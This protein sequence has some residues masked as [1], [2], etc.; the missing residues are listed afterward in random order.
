MSKDESEI[1]RVSVRVPPFY[2]DKPALWFMQLE[3]QFVLSNITSDSTKFHY[4]IAQLDSVYASIVEDIITGPT[5]PNKYEQLKT[6]LIKRLSVSREKKINQLLTNEELGDRKPTQFLRHLK[7][8]A[9]KDVPEEFMR[10]IWT[11]RL[12]TS[13]QSI[14]AG[15]A[16]LPLDE[17]AEL[18]DRIHEVVPIHPQVAATSSSSMSHSLTQ[19]IAALTQQ[20]QVLASKVDRMSRQRGRSKTPNGQ[21]G[22][23]RSSSERRSSANFKKFPTCWYHHKFGDKANRCVQ[24]CNFAGNGRGNL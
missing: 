19:E 9:G 24:P 3:S 15:Q 21:R 5:A 13:T 7:S 4:A 12:P 11:S 14:I 2:A 18:A 23:T 16:K 1:N 17:V 10:S 6:E 8:L 22:R 20:M